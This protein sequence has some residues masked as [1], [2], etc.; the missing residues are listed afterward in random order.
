MDKGPAQS[1]SYSNGNM[2][3]VEG[4]SWPCAADWHAGW[5]AGDF[6]SHWAFMP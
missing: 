5:D 4:K 3:P 6:Q 1:N 2:R